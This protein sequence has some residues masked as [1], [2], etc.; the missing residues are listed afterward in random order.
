MTLDPDIR[1]T[2]EQ[3]DEF[4]KI[5]SA[6][7]LQVAREGTLLT[8]SPYLD[9]ADGYQAALT[10]LTYARRLIRVS[11]PAPIPEEALGG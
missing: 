7:A 10:T 1:M 4:L 5:L 6:L 11:F 9:Y 2:F 8:A 3:K